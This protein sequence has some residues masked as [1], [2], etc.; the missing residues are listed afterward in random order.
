MLEELQTILKLICTVWF[1]WRSFKTVTV[2]RYT[3]ISRNEI[4][5][6]I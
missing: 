4:G 3:N 2:T 6:E 1:D 5:V